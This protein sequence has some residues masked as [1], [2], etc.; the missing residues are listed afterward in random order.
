MRTRRTGEMNRSEAG[1]WMCFYNSG[2]VTKVANRHKAGPGEIHP[3][4]KTV[5]H[6]APEI[7]NL[8]CIFCLI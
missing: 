3:R 6:S 1:E 2:G 7:F 8:T 5:S 4:G